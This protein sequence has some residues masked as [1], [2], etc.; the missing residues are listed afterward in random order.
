[1]EE[2]IDIP[3]AINKSREAGSSIADINEPIN[4]TEIDSFVVMEGNEQKSSVSD[5]TNGPILSII[6][7]KTHLQ[8]ETP[9][10]IEILQSKSLEK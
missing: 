2:L 1:M 9:I 10:P 7:I 6:S 8:E 3:P 5:E 4:G